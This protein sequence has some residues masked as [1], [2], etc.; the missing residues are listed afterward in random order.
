MN[1]TELASSLA[2]LA[3]DGTSFKTVNAPKE[4]LAQ[5][6]SALQAP[7]DMVLHC[8]DCG[9]QHIDAPE[10]CR[11]PGAPGVTLEPWTNPP[12]RSH[13]CSGCGYVWRP[14]DVPTNGV[15][16]VETTGVADSPIPGTTVVAIATGDLNTE[17]RV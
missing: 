4:L 14:A 15:A 13:L 12:H 10:H 6:S 11:R 5:A 8:P 1:R 7:I 16:A 17:G 2:R 9:L 3:K